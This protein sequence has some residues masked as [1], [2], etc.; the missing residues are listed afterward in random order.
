MFNKAVWLGEIPIA[1]QHPFGG[2]S[3]NGPDSQCPAG[4]SPAYPGGPCRGGVA[5]GGL[6]GIPSSADV[7]TGTFTTPSMPASYYMGGARRPIPVVNL[8]RRM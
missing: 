3:L 4:Q 1:R 5:T 6:P 7:S 2:R 8:R